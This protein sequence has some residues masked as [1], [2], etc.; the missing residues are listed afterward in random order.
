ML[1]LILLILP[2][3]TV[4]DDSNGIFDTAVKEF[5][6]NNMTRA[7]ELFQQASL[8]SSKKPQSLY[9]LGVI[10]SRQKH[11]GESIGYFRKALTL[12]PRDR[13]TRQNLK[14][15][16]AQVP[17]NQKTTESNWNLYRNLVLSQGTFRDFM[18]V[19]FLAMT[20]FL[21]NLLKILRLR[22]ND[23]TPPLSMLIIWGGLFVLTFLLSASKFV[24]NLDTRIT[25][26]QAKGSVRSGP[27]ANTAELGAATEGQEFLAL[28]KEGN[29][30]QIR[31][32][33]GT[34][35]W[36]ESTQAMVTSEN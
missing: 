23:E 29:W 22:K 31:L 17:A 8:N 5:Q 2:E 34:I 35:G 11:W 20:W 33:D 27:D 15:A 13:D 36:V 21:Y 14:L 6:N 18:I 30:F 24:D 28:D 26:T 3:V 25:I 4:A 19:L 16:L 10:A 7:A 9:N 1:L 12:S 32:N